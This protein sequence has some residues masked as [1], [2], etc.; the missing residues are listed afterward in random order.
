MKNFSQYHK[1]NNVILYEKTFSKLL[2]VNKVDS[3]NGLDQLSQMAK[4]TIWF[5]LLSYKQPLHLYENFADSE[6]RAILPGYVFFLRFE[7]SCWI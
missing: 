3:I 2:R 6:S 4:T 1:E 7:S 5:E